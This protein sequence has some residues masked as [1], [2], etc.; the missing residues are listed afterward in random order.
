VEDHARAVTPSLTVCLATSAK[1][2]TAAAGWSTALV[3]GNPGVAA[4]SADAPPDLPEAE[5]EAK[6][7]AALYRTSS[8]LLGARATKADF[9]LHAGQYDVVHFAGHAIANDVRPELSRLLFAGADETARS[10]F[11]RDIATERFS[12]T[13]LVVLGA[14]ST[15]AGRI[16]RGEGVLSLARPFLAAGVPAVVASLWDVN[17]RASHRLLVAFHRALRRSGDVAEALRRA[18]LELMGDPDPQL[19]AIGRGASS[20][21]ILAIRIRSFRHRRHG[22]ASRRSS[23]A[24]WRP[25]AQPTNRGCEGG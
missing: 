20:R 14:C 2:P 10:L 6:E 17:D 19:Q 5:A 11:A 24:R 4:G 16:R 21:S 12:A 9:I 13:R 3:M 25:S 23:A 1:P 15:S 22:R 18:Q 8:L 7:V